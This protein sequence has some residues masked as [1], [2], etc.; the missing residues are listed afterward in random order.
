MAKIFT[1]PLNN[2]S[3]YLSLDNNHYRFMF[4]L[5]SS[6]ILLIA[7][8]LR[9]ICMK[10]DLWFDEIWSIVMI[11]S[12]GNVG[13]II[14]KL[15]HDNRHIINTLIIYLLGDTE[16]P[17]IYRT[18]ALIAGIATIV[19][20]ALI[21]RLR[22]KLESIFAT[23]MVGFSYLLI[24]YSTEARGYSFL[25][26]FT[27]LSYYNALLYY[28]KKS[29]LLALLY[30]L[31]LIFGLLSHYIFIVFLISILIWSFMVMRQQHNTYNSIYNLVILYAPSCF[32]LFMLY[33]VDLR[34][35]YIAGLS[36]GPKLQLFDVFLST[37]A[38]SVG[39]PK[40]G[41]AAVAAGIGVTIVSIWALYLFR[42]DDQL[43]NILFITIIIMSLLIIYRLPYVRYFCIAE[44][45]ILLLLSYFF[46]YICRK[47]FIGKI[48]IIILMGFITTGNFI[49]ILDLAK[50]GRGSYL[51]PL[52]FI[53]NKS[54]SNPI[55]IGS[56]DFYMVS[57]VIS[58]Y[59]KYLKNGNKIHVLHREL[60]L[61]DNPEWF[62]KESSN[63]H[64]RKDYSSKIKVKDNLIINHDKYVLVKNYY[65]SDLS[66]FNW[67]I[68]HKENMVP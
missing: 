48:L 60:S 57:I 33:I 59:K 65:H 26:L 58:Y 29:I 67:H 43:F 44:L 62:I 52:R 8:I 34:H 50:Y 45:F 16:S 19:V 41:L 27:L 64:N 28:R 53:E 25:C 68:Y 10:N 30:N 49:H 56:N 13:D 42:K 2:F 36:G 12:V 32:F 14:T 21:G 31:T 7:S 6:L 18:P 1:K 4:I 55:I 35:I 23:L 37:L 38:L 3:R 11:N 51:E 47:T 17:L 9:I 61:L 46:A 39:A 24:H 66:G 15:H 63:Y 40:F 54:E 20:A 22:G 5:A